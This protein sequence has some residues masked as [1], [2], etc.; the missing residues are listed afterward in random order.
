MIPRR[1]SS[2]RPVPPWRSSTSSGRPARARCTRSTC[3]PRGTATWSST[4]MASWIRCCRWR[5]RRRRTTSRGP[6]R[7]ALARICRGVLELFG[8]RLH[9][10]GRRTADPSADGPVHLAF[11]ASP[12]GAARGPFARIDAA[13]QLAETYPGQ[14]DGALVMCGFVGG[15]TR[16]IEYMA[17]ARIDLRLL[18]SR[19]DSRD[20]IRDPG[21]PGLPPRHAALQRGAGKSDRRVRSAVQDTS[22]CRRG[23]SSG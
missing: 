17:N 21:R 23:R 22:I 4:P 19:G 10:Q 1:L 16:E 12:P 9:P 2:R 8:Q 20:G 3:R 14:Y 13:L 18:L 7:A 6:R 5:C 15:T 11:L